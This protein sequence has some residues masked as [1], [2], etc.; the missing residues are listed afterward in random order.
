A[1]LKAGDRVVATARNPE[2][3]VEL[4]SRHAENIRSVPLDVTN[5]AQAK[6]AFD[7]AIA[8]FGLPRRARKQCRLRLCVPRRRYVT[9][10]FSSADR[11][12]PIWRH[13]YDQGRAPL[14]S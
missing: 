5:E 8:S 4:E 11:D 1:V 3:L 9:R 12:Q 14:L 13:Y 10:R 2:Q 7:A 6:A